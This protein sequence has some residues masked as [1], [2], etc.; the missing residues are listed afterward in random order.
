MIPSGLCLAHH[1]IITD[2]G[3]YISQITRKN[4]STKITMHNS[5]KK[6]K[7][8]TIAQLFNIS[9]SC[10]AALRSAKFSLLQGVRLS[11]NLF[12]LSSLILRRQRLTRR[13][14]AAQS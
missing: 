12:M 5:H 2:S 1:L 10:S 7:A 8:M 9:N 13:R 3:L 14:R 6:G 11:Q 4:H